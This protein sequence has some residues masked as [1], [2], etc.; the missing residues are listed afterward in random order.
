MVAHGARLGGRTRSAA[1]AGD[2]ISRASCSRERGWVLSDWLAGENST[3]RAA[4]AGSRDTRVRRAR[5][6]AGAVRRPRSARSV[7]DRRAA[8]RLL[9]QSRQPGRCRR[10]GD[11]LRGRRHRRAA[12]AGSRRDLPVSDRQDRDPR[13]AASSST[14]Q[15]LYPLV[16]LPLAQAPPDGALRR[17]P[18]RGTTTASRPTRA[19]AARRSRSRTC[20]SS[21][22]ATGS[23]FEYITVDSHRP[24]AS[25]PEPSGDDGW[26]VSYRFRY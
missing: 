22:S 10:L 6:P 26:Q 11:A 8:P 17:L 3:M 23:A 5:R 24:S 18:G 12:A 20:S 21:G 13:R 15:A 9:R 1:R 4:V 7:E 25:Q 2:R 16:S 14:I 19:S